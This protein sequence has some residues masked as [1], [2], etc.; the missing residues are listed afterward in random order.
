MSNSLGL[1]E[2]LSGYMRTERNVNVSDNYARSFASNAL[3]LCLAILDISN[4]INVNSSK[5]NR[6]F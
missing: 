6:R 1:S 4:I 2:G 5:L 3:W